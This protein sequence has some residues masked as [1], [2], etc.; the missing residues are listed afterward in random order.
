MKQGVNN[1]ASSS[2]ATRMEYVLS[3]WIANPLLPNKDICRLAGISEDTFAR[4]RKDENFMRRFHEKCRER[5][6]ALEAKAVEKLE[7]QLDNDNWQ[8]I[9]YTLDANGYAATQKME[10]D[11][12]T[13]FAL[14]MGDDDA[15]I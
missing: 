11:N 12:K 4:Y 5:F 7:Q 3:V 13:S 6:T 9:K 14:V 15:A 8:A 1:M 2:K 10:I